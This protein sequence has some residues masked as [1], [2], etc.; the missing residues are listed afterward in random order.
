M[1]SASEAYALW[2]KSGDCLI[3]GNVFGGR[4]LVLDNTGCRVTGNR[5]DHSV[6]RCITDNAGNNIIVGNEFDTPCTTDA[7]S[8]VQ[9]GGN[10]PSV[11]TG[12]LFKP[13]SGYSGAMTYAVTG[14]GGPALIA[15]NVLIP[16]T[17]GLISG[18]NGGAK[19]A[20]NLKYYD[21]DQRGLVHVSKNYNVGLEDNAIMVG[22]QTAPVTVTL[23]SATPGAAGRRLLIKDT[24]LA[25]TYNITV[26]PATGQYLEGASS[27]TIN[28][29]DGKIAVICDGYNWWL[30]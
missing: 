10:N 1:C 12:N 14:S 24:G 11:F 6:G 8:A 4:S 17:S 30:A 13:Y 2:A 25:A 9:L 19:L 15:A 3:S 7:Q 5:W 20:S 18:W 16:G 26:K 22:G 29:T 21:D 28:T 23:P 27:L